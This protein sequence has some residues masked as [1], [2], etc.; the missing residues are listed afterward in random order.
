L[1]GYDPAAPLGVGSRLLPAVK[2]I[3]CNSREYL[4]P[5]TSGAFD[6]ALAGIGQLREQGVPFQVDVTLT[7]LDAGQLEDR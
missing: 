5:R 6:D 3:D 4:P 1:E 7:K 2:L